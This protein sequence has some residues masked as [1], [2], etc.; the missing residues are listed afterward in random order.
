MYKVGRNSFKTIK[1]TP[2]VNIIEAPI[3]TAVKPAF[4]TSTTS[5]LPT[6]LPT[7]IPPAA[8]IPS[9]TIKVIDARFIAI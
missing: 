6:L 7:L 2:K 5:F 1:I 8:D 3:I 9:T 4:R